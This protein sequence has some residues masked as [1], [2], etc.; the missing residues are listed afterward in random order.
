MKTGLRVA[1][2]ICTGT[3]VLG[4]ALY[5]LRHARHKEITEGWDL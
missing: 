1:F 3:L 5:S 4:Y 2:L